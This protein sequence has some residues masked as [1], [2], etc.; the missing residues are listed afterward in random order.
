MTFR[1]MSQRLL[2]AVVTMWLVVTFTFIILRATGDPTD[3]LLPDDTPTEVVEFYRRAWGLDKPLY[4]QYLIYFKS[5]FRGDLGRSFRDNRDAVAVML[6]RIPAT[7]RLGCSALALA[8][9]SGVL[10]GIFAALHRNSVLDRMTMAFAVFGY[11]MPNF[12]LGILL[13]FL[14][15]MKLRILPSAGSETFLHMIMP[16]ITLTTAHAAGIA[17]FSRSAMLEVLNEPYI[18]TARAK[19]LSYRRRLLRHAL[20]NAMIPIMTIAGLKVGHL[21]GGAIIIETVFAW[22]GVGRLL[23]MSVAT[24]D[25]AVVQAIVLMLACSMIAANLSVDL[26]Y[27]WVD[28]R[29]RLGKAEEGC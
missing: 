8:I 5:V 28:P 16:L 4:E 26:L 2:R 18:R 1:Y 23:V 9:V 14:F 6:E 25:L 24:R 22:P 17:R 10:L 20:P 7:L 12:F 27:G 19:G 11:S 29:I 13:I 15:A 3:T 21:I